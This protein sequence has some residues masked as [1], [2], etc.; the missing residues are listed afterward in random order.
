MLQEAFSLFVDHAGYLLIKVA[1]G[2]QKVYLFSY[3]TIFFFL[4]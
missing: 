4:S 1:D 3:K 2:S